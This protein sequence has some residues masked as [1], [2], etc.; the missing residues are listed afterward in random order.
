MDMAM[1]LPGEPS[2]GRHRP[3]A[4]NL[5]DIEARL[6]GGEVT[7]QVHPRGVARRRQPG[8]GERLPP[9]W[10]WLGTADPQRLTGLLEERDRPLAAGY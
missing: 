5:P 3:H 6:R 2:G 10:K 9:L 1:C 7:G 4:Q 8:R